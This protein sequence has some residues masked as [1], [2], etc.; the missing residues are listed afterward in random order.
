MAFGGAGL[1][2]WIQ[3]VLSYKMKRLPRAHPR[4]RLIR[5]VLSVIHAV[6]F[7]VML[8]ATKLSLDKFPHSIKEI[9]TW[10]SDQPGYPEHLSATFAEWIMAVVSSTY[11]L[12]FIGELKVIQ[13]K[14]LVMPISST[15]EGNGSAVVANDDAET[16]N[17]R[18]GSEETL[19]TDNRY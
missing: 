17:D 1:Y 11:F 9:K 4:C 18:V 19:S 15:Q 7:L 13:T 3:A 5:V 14:V 16:A 6:C 8:I 2:C 10:T 12:T